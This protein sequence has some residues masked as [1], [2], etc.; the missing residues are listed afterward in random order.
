MSVLF[1]PYTQRGVT[2]RNR[3]VVAPMCMYSS[4]DGFANDWHLVHL[5]SRAVGGAALV[6]AEATA[7][8]AEGRINSGDLGLWN[9]AHIPGLR[10]ITDFIRAQGAVAGIQLAHAGRKAGT[11]PDGART[12]TPEQGGWSPIVAPSAV[13][14]AAATHATPHALSLAEIASVVEAFAAA[15]ARAVTAGF[16][17]VELHAAHG[18]LF[19]QFLSPLANQRTD[20]YGGSQA[21][22]FRFLLEAVAAVRAV[23]PADRPL[24]VRLSVTDYVEGGWTLDDSVALSMEL[25]AAGVD[26]V[27]C[28]SGA[29]VPGVKI[30]V[31]PGFQV[32]FAERIRREAG[33]ATGAVGLITEP[34]QAEAIVASG[35]A[36]MVLLA[37][38]MLR[39]PYWPQHAAAALGVKLN[40]WAQ[41]YWAVKPR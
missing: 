22:R 10:R 3:L 13:P 34:T 30:P 41:Q 8:T 21:N 28:S 29:I 6:I 11:T 24:W 40:Y 32:P 17:M 5:G 2:F 26:L 1:S 4:Q 25:K 12:L 9:E 16:E 19:H 36:D 35:Q 14:F 31:A 38:Q 27:D 37:R 33:V 18:Y 39:D 23:L 20:H 15:A 7:V